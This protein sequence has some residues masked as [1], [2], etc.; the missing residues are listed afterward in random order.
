[1]LKGKNLI[2]NIDNCSLNANEIAIWWLGQHSFIIKNSTGI[3]YIDPFLIN[4]PERLIPSMLKPNEIT[5]ASYI[6]G[7]HDHIDHIDRTC[8]PIIAKY[9]PNAKF[10][11]PE[12]IKEDLIKNLNISLER[13]VGLEDMNYF[14]NAGLKITAIASAH[15][16]L[17]KDSKGR[18][19]FLGYIIENN[20]KTIYH[21][22]DCC[23]YEGLLTK[24]KKWDIDLMILP[25]NGRDAKRLKSGIIGNMTYQE[26]VDLAGAANTKM[27]IPAHYDMFKNN[28]G[29]V[30]DFIEY[31]N[32]KYPSI[33]SQICEYAKCIKLK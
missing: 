27:V 13:F 19:L 18:D 24:L 12:S 4:M 33:K 8:W 20:R 32:I 9:S 6:L 25:I 14:E 3:I 22:G 5:N 23:I 2:D 10:I 29:P 26:A 1:M 17:E 11:V 21:S 7:T 30:D 31:L 16:N 15:E 28:L